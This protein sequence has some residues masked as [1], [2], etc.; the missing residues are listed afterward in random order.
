MTSKTFTNIVAGL[1]LLLGGYVVDKFILSGAIQKSV[2]KLSLEVVKVFRY[3][4]NIKNTAVV[5]D[6]KVYLVHISSLLGPTGWERHQERNWW[7]LLP[8]AKE[9]R[10]W[11][12]DQRHP[13]DSIGQLEF[14]PGTIFAK[15]GWQRVEGLIIGPFKSLAHLCHRISERKIDQRSLYLNFPP[16]IN[17]DQYRCS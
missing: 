5:F 13:E 4:V 10:G 14:A 1:A 11:H 7:I 12:V 17:A 8:S 9:P 15:Q 3:P 16:G 6:G 2:Q